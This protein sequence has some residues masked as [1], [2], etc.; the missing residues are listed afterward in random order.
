MRLKIFAKQE[1]LEAVLV[2]NL[3]NRGCFSS[4][5]GSVSRDRGKVL[6]PILPGKAKGYNRGKEGTLLA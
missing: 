1:G 3:N 5:E 6:S 2:N 4:L